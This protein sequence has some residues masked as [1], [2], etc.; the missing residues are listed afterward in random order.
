M[1]KILLNILLI[2]ASLSIGLAYAARETKK[3]STNTSAYMKIPIYLD[4][5]CS[6][7]TGT[8]EGFAT[9]PSELFKDGGPWPVRLH[10]FNKGKRIIGRSVEIKDVIDEREIWANCH[11]GVL[12]NIFW[13]KKGSCGAY[14]QEGLLVSKNMMILKLHYENAMAGTDMMLILTRKSN[15]YPYSV[16]KEDQDFVLGKIRTCH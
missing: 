11:R 5:Q 6:D 15:N 1:K 9:D 12:K 16:P 13:G 4:A 2:T 7:Y 14:S 8:W 10:L 3:V